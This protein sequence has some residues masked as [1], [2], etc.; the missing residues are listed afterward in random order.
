VDGGGA[1][2]GGVGVAFD[3]AFALQGGED[4]GEVG[5]LQAGRGG[6][7]AG[8]GAVVLVEVAHHGALG[9]GER[10]G[11]GVAVAEELDL[12]GDHEREVG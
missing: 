1:A 6:D 8:C 4:G 3:Q 5:A 9:L 11:L 10:Y 12:A 2:V 7:H